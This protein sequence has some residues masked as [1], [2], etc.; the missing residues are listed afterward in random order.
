MEVGNVQLAQTESDPSAPR[1]LRDVYGIGATVVQA[2]E[3]FSWARYLVAPENWCPPRTMVR[4]RISDKQVLDG[5]S[6]EIDCG[7]VSVWTTSFSI[8]Y[9][10]ASSV[11]GR[12][13]GS[14]RSAGCDGA[15]RV[16]RTVIALK[17]PVIVEM[18]VFPLE[19]G[20]VRV[21]FKGDEV[22]SR[23]HQVDRENNLRFA[24]LQS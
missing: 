9:F 2:P 23:T 18:Q 21:Q 8:A 1:Y 15:F 17:T 19:C 14:F 10:D 7:L 5:L 3:W 20:A 24:D 13:T 22:A 16:T 6:D 11:R 12:S 4:V